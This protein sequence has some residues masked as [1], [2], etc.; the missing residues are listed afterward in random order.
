MVAGA[1]VRQPRNGYGVRS[2]KGG[3]APPP[4]GGGGGA[5][6]PPPYIIILIVVTADGGPVR[7]VDR[8]S[9][10]GLVVMT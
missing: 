10:M 2:E 7:L 4:P 9:P 5:A 3:R 6:P 1:V 8:D